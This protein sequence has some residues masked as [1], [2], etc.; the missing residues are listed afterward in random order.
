MDFERR[1]WE[2]GV[3]EFHRLDV[4]V[5]EEIPEERVRDQPI[6][7]HREMNREPPSLEARIQISR[8]LELE[9]QATGEL[10][11]DVRLQVPPL[12]VGRRRHNLEFSV[13]PQHQ[14]LHKLSLD[15]K[16]LLGST[17]RRHS[18]SMAHGQRL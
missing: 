6:L 17:D 9:Y 7:G 18:P 10:A 3:G 14:E 4:Q 12:V 13:A 2:N 15:D 16:S 11:T 8:A 5:G 1:H